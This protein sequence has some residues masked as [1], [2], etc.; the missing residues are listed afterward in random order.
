M[1]PPLSPVCFDT[2]DAVSFNNRSFILSIKIIS[3]TP[4]SFSFHPL[5]LYFLLLAQAALRIVILFGKVK[6]GRIKAKAVLFSILLLSQL[7]E[8]VEFLHS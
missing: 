6:Q 2:S 4:P 1:A 8:C 3:A 7:T 5:F